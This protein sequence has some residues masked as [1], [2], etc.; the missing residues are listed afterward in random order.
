MTTLL[1]VRHGLTE[2]TGPVL[3]GWTPGVSLD[4]RGRAQARAVG[5]RLASVPLAAVVSSPLDRCL[6]TAEAIVSA[7]GRDGPREIHRDER[8]GEV[9]YGD[10]T[11]RPL[12]ELAGE[13]LWKVV[14]A[15]PSAV[16]F[17]GPEGE[18]MAAAQ[19]RAV[20]AVRDWNA[21]IAA[22]AGPGA[23]YLVCSHGD[24]IK[25]IVADALGL[26]LDQFQRIHVEPASLTVIRYTELRPFVIRLNDTGGGTDGLLPPP[27]AAPEGDA[28]V[29]GGA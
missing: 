6:Q 24:I 21:R 7:P 17:P 16:T 1:L 19:H 3:A 4:D 18:A 8:F 10:W 25:A 12:K 15:H 26:H 29:G 2:L 28:A 20:A 13:P 22:E 5:E 23:A 11:G 14:Q 27:D 9:R